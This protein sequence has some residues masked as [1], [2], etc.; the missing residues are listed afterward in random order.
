MKA[1]IFR[2]SSAG[3][4]L[5]TR[6]RCATVRQVV[7]PLSRAQALRRYPTHCPSQVLRNPCPQSLAGGG[8]PGVPPR[9]LPSGL[10]PPSIHLDRAC[11][12]ERVA[13]ESVLRSVSCQSSSAT[14]S[15]WMRWRNVTASLFRLAFIN[16]D[17]VEPHPAAFITLTGLHAPRH[18]SGIPGGMRRPGS[19]TEIMSACR[20]ELTASRLRAREPVSGL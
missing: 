16:D 4:L 15:A 8:L 14:S 11:D 5:A 19:D 1:P 7:A 17:L 18:V 12:P 20:E 3:G 6:G 2:S 10:I 13:I 9:N